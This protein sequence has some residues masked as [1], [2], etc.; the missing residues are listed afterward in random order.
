[1]SSLLVERLGRRTLFVLSELIM[2]FSLFALGAFFYLKENPE[3]N[4]VVIESIGWLPLLSLILFIAAFGIGAGPIPWLMSSEI[5]P[6]KVKG[7][8]VS[9]ATFTNWMLAFVVT[10]TFVSIQEALTSAGAFWIF[11]TFC[12]FG[13]FFGLFILPE[14]KGKTPEEI[15][16]LF[17]KKSKNIELPCML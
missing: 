3:T 4:S 15:Q 11:G 9:I 12:V 5:L 6:A 17:N 13:A 10:K 7:P 14:R 1:M 8:G 16:D 2:S